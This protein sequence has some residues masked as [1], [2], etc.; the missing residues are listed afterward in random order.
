MVFKG[1]VRYII[2]RYLKNYIEQL[3]DEKLNYD[4][5]TGLFLIICLL[6][7]ITVSFF[8]DMSP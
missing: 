5:R 8:K 2:N 4:F 7:V 1:I 6:I 3:D